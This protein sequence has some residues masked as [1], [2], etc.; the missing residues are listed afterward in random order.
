MQTETVANAGK[1]AGHRISQLPIGRT[2]AYELIRQGKLEARKSGR[3]TIVI[4]WNEYLADLPKI[5][6]EAA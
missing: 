3:A 2:H 6:S 4:N 5:G 1:P